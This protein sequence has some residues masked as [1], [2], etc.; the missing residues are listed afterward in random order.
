MQDVCVLDFLGE[1]VYSFH[2]IIKEVGPQNAK[3]SWREKSEGWFDI[4]SNI[5]EAE[6][7]SVMPEH[8]NEP[9]TV[10]CFHT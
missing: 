1:K 5:T 9:R 8:G 10:C 6:G 4:T 2:Q 7:K 3:N